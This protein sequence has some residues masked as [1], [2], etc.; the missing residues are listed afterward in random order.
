MSVEVKGMSI[1]TSLNGEKKKKKKRKERS[2]SS[3]DA[4]QAESFPLQKEKKEVNSGRKDKKDKKEKKERSD[5]KRRRSGSKDDLASP[6]VAVQGR[7]DAVA[8]NGTPE[9]ASA[10]AESDSKKKKKK[11]KSS[12]KKH[13]KDKEESGKKKR[14]K[15]DSNDANTLESKDANEGVQEDDVI[16]DVSSSSQ[17]AEE[18]TAIEVDNLVENNAKQSSK[19][20]PRSRDKT[21]S[22]KEAGEDRT[23]PL[24]CNQHVSE[25]GKG[26]NSGLTELPTVQEILE[27]ATKK[28]NAFLHGYAAVPLL[29][30]EQ[31]KALDEESQGKVIRATAGLCERL[32]YLIH[33]TITTANRWTKSDT[34]DDGTAMEESVVNDMMRL[35]KVPLA[36]QYVE[37]TLWRR[38]AQLNRDLLLAASRLGFGKGFADNSARGHGKQGLLLHCENDPDAEF[39]SYREAHMKTIVEQ[40]SESL[41]KMREAESMDADRVQFLLRCLD[42]GA[43]LFGNLKCLEKKELNNNNSLN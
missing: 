28:R 24:H 2:D 37:M 18:A 43:S 11:E 36:K 33:D 16:V 29:L 3:K 23:A 14:R 5:R 32:M 21:Q 1:E 31:V 10:P 13:R 12:H 19:T 30:P 20:S 15:S 9:L 22:S 4:A 42:S 7:N 8:L 6:P 17:A 27:K 35:K 40:Y 39:V 26:D 25:S 34:K 41:E 38:I